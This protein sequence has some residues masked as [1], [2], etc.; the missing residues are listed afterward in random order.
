LFFEAVF[1]KK[2][3]RKPERHDSSFPF[4]SPAIQDVAER[5]KNEVMLARSFAHGHLLAPLNNDFGKPEVMPR[6]EI[7]G[8]LARVRGVRVLRESTSTLQF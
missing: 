3:S 2:G 5:R 1:T 4:F 8:Q 6:N 7:G